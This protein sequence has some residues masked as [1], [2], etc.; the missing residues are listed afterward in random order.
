M[1]VGAVNRHLH[2][3]IDDGCI[4]MANRS[5]RPLAFRLPVAFRLPANG[6]L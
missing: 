4:E 2:E 6:A 5:V 1:A 3:M